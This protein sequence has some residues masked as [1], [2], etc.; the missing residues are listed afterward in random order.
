MDRVCLCSFLPVGA[1]YYYRIKLPLKYLPGV[2]TIHEQS[3][4]T[5]V[6]I[7]SL[8]DIDKFDTIHIFGVMEYQLY[9]ILDWVR[10]GK[11]IILDLDDDLLHIPAHSDLLS[12]MPDDIR[13]SSIELL[14]NVLQN[15]SAITVTTEALK[16]VY[17]EYNKNI[18]ILP[19]Y[20]DPD[21]WNE[22][23]KTPQDYNEDL[24][25]GYQG[26]FSHLKDLEMLKDVI[27]AVY[28]NEELKNKTITTF[29]GNKIHNIPKGWN[30][31]KVKHLDFEKDFQKF[32]T[33]LW[34]LNFDLLF[35]P[36]ENTQFNKCR[37][38]IKVL[39]AG[40]CKVPVIA[41]DLE[42]YKWLPEEY[43]VKSKEEW[44]NKTL[45]WLHSGK[46]YLLEKGRKLYNL[47]VEDW[48]I[49]KH[50]NKWKEVYESL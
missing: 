14:I 17:K 44:I 28:Q 38:A 49:R 4:S 21:N 12:K 9:Y 19:N 7:E 25:I 2:S 35:A 22:I 33:T 34:T 39:E 50:I 5:F 40:M 24:H 31:E 27:T 3:V 1:G 41:Q 46:D 6:P 30:K 15:V 29:W 43:K 8:I 47:I 37:S 18:F 13:Q 11:K 26:S 23:Y 36:L 42:P 45:D 16:E 48:D 32:L 20:I 10:K